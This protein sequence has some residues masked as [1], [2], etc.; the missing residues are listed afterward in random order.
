VSII[1]GLKSLINMVLGKGIRIGY[2]TGKPF[3]PRDQERTDP[4][5]DMIKADNKRREE[6]DKF[7]R[8]KENVK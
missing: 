2:S 4:I 5:E 3:D 8:I 1:S 7:S 6:N